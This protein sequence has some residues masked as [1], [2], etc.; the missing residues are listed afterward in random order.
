MASGRNELTPTH[1]VLLADAMSTES[2]KKVA[3]N[4]MK[5]GME[6]IIPIEDEN[7]GNRSEKPFIRDV[8]RTWA[9][10]SVTSDQVK[11]KF[12]KKIFSNQI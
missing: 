11:V 2:V 6:E 4:Y 3:R 10:K 7:I 1:I 5:L 8:F 12:K 9:N